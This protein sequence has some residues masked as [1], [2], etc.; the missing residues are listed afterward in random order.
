M[1]PHTL[2]E[3]VP[4]II[5]HGYLLFFIAAIIEGS[6]VSTA[7]GIVAGLG[8]FN[9]FFV[10]LIAVA[11]DLVGDLA[12][13]FIGRYSSN[14]LNSKFFK[15]FGL[16]SEKLEE[17]KKILH[18]HTNKALVLIKLSPL[19]GPPGLICVGAVRIPFK[20][21]F[22][23]TLI[24]STVKAVLFSVIGFYSAKSYLS[25]SKALSHTSYTII[26]FILFIVIIH[27]LYRKAVRKLSQ[28]LEE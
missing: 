16:H 9:I 24:I 8:F 15:F 18:I 20:K 13:Y 22:K 19:I 3:L 28:K 4:W 21:Y 6:L 11:G 7:A 23:T 1:I 10:I 17:M 27:L 5:T 12:Y 26:G 25:I 2:T 14:I